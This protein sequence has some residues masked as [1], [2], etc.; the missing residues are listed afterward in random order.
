MVNKTQDLIMKATTTQTELKQIVL[1]ADDIRNFGG[2]EVDNIQ[3]ADGCRPSYPKQPSK[4]FLKNGHTTQ[5]VLDYATKLTEYGK[6][7]EVYHKEKEEYKKATNIIN[8]AI[9]EYI[10]QS[11]GLY[12]IPEQ[13]QSKVYNLAYENGHSD[14]YYSVYYKLCD[15]IDIF[16]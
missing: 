4:P 9:I 8:S 10:K 12:T 15:L 13:Y 7:M 2:T 6:N 1:T 3:K 16:E 11:S 14:G 5:D